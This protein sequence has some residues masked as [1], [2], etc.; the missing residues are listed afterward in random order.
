M[1]YDG[2]T[3]GPVTTI[4]KIRRYRGMGDIKS[5][6]IY[7]L[8]FEENS[9]DIY[10]TLLARGKESMRVA[11]GKHMYFKGTN[12][13]NQEQVDGQIM[14]DFE[15]ALAENP[16]WAP[17]ILEPGTN[18]EAL[19][20]KV[21]KVAM[22]QTRKRERSIRIKEEEILEF[23]VEHYNVA[24]HCRWNG[25]QI[26]NAFQIAIALAEK[27]AYNKGKD[28]EQP[29]F[30][31]GGSNKKPPTVTLRR[32]HFEKVA[33]ANDAFG[34]YLVDVSEMPNAQR[35]Y[36]GNLRNDQISK[37]SMAKKEKEPSRGKKKARRE[38]VLS[39]RESEDRDD[40]SASD[41][42]TDTEQGSGSG[43]E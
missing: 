19:S 38:E 35:V 5:L 28:E 10:K 12:S 8:R 11:N 39:E 15:Q 20:I 9:A 13:S 31:R 36:E 33:K 34:N 26:R 27:D 23:A 29:K 24:E 17:H 18:F 42:E 30:E 25:R 4:F 21:W 1:D 22:S 16:R 6:I 2:N 3:F 37:V 41:Q 40:T 14:I 43:R 32:R 7:P